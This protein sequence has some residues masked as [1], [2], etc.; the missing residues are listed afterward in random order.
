[1]LFDEFGE[2]DGFEWLSELI[3]EGESFPQ[4]NEREAC[5]FV[6]YKLNMADQYNAHGADKTALDTQLLNDVLTGVKANF[7]VVYEDD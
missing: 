1:M 7:E 5:N 2:E 6:I 4:L 3:I